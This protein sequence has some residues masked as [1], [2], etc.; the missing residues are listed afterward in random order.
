MPRRYA[1]YWRR[2]HPGRLLLALRSSHGIGGGVGRMCASDRARDAVLM[3]HRVL[4]AGSGV[5]AV[6]AVL[7]LRHLA[8][9][10]FD[11]DLLA[12]AHALEHKP[13]VGRDAV[14]ARRPAAA[15]PS[16]ARQPVRRDARRGRAGRRGRRRPARTPRE[17]RRPRLRPSAG[18]G[19]RAPGARPP[20]LADLPRTRGRAHA[21]VGA[22][23]GRARPPPATR[24]RRASR[25]DLAAARLRARHHGR[26]GRRAASATRR[27]RSSRRSASR[28]G[29]SATPP[30]RRCASS[31]PS[32]ASNWSRAPAPAH[33]T[34]DVLWL[35]DGRAII[36]DTV[37]SLPVLRGPRHP[38]PPVR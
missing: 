6:E 32:A 24:G 29:S 2:R 27:S 17:R 1:R 16:R 37:L 18:R 33:V 30:A 13:G 21:R 20:G 23:G 14:R 31:W 11:I 38:G 12:P 35:E 15:R 22:R 3:T 19:R 10:N 25:R 26:D 7:A 36:G 5:A 9:R 8:G 4:I 28:S 34:D